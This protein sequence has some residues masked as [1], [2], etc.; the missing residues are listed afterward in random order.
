MCVTDISIRNR[1]TLIKVIFGNRYDRNSHTGVLEIWLSFNFIQRITSHHVSNTDRLYFLPFTFNL[2]ILQKW[3]LGIE[4]VS[5]IGMQGLVQNKKPSFPI[6]LIN[7]YVF[8]HS[9]FVHAYFF[10]DRLIVCK[11]KLSEWILGQDENGGS[12]H[13]T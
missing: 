10:L 1:H 3:F 11:G 2:A 6:I 4:T 9:S 13:L 8:K 7:V 5:L 12:Q